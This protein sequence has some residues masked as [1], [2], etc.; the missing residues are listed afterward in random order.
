MMQKNRTALSRR[1][2]LGGGAAMAGAAVMGAPPAAAAKL[3]RQHI[4]E[5]TP[6]T[7]LPGELWQT[8]AP[9]DWPVQPFPL[10]SVGLGESVSPRA[11]YQY[12]VLYRASPVDRMLCA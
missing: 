2:V 12:T 1:R 6:A 9:Q 4:G 11:L 7:P 3:E 10:N 5:R 8:D